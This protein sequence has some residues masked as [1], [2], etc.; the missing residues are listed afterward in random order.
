M[1]RDLSARL[2]WLAA[3]G[4]LAGGAVAWVVAMAG[5]GRASVPNVPLAVPVTV[6][7][8]WSLIGSGLLAWRPGPGNRLGPALVFTGFAWF[9]S[10]LPDVHNPVLFTAGEAVYSFFYAGFL[11]LILSFPVGRLRGTLD[12][13]LMAVTVVLVTVGQLAWLLFADSRRLICATC[14]ANLLEVARDD[15]IAKLLR[16]SPESVDTLI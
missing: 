12:R 3:A 2:V 14:P 15:R 11:Y 13:V 9:A 5:P 16:G 7:V 6:L 10:T 1:R 4:L 8:G